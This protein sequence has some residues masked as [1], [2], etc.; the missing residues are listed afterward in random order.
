ML[1]KIFLLGGT[2]D[3]INIIHFLKGE[4]IEES[5]E[6]F[7][8]SHSTNGF[9]EF[10][11]GPFSFYILNTTTTDHGAN[12]AKSAGADDII[13]KPLPLDEIISIL[14]D[15]N[16]DLIIDATHPFAK[17]ITSSAIEAAKISEVPYIR[18]ERPSLKEN[19]N[20]PK[21]HYVDSSQELGKLIN[22]KF[23]KSRILHLAGVNTLENIFEI[24]KECKNN[25]VSKKNFYVRVLPLEFSIKKCKNLGINEDHIIAMEGIFSKEFN[26]ALMNEFQTDLVITKES[27]DVG[28]LPSKLEAAIELDIDIILINRPKISSLKKEYIVNDL[29]GLKS[30]INRLF[31]RYHFKNN[32]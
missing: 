23:S 25:L 29:N 11:P 22:E 8:D 5:L 24:L 31:S 12:L 30:K 1:F 16:F 4:N 32:I 10:F 21:M 28:G 20:Y 17:N 6:K 27:G 15:N 19:L 2:K 7:P 26:K 18:F 13:A 3:S 9:N 14:K